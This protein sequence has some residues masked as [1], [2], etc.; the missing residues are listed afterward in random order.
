MGIFLVIAGVALGFIA[1]MIFGTAQ[2]VPQQLV[3]GEL[4]I[5]GAVLFASGA[6]VG[7]VDNLRAAMKPAAPAK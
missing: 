5:C 7:A 6:I 4:A 2:A 1:F 3:A